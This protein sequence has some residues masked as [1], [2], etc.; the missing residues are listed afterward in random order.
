LV[1]PKGIT[2]HSYKSNLVLKA[3]FHSSPSFIRIWW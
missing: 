2:N 1:N 3:A